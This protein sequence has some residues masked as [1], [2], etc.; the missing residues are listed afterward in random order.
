MKKQ[1]T[2]HRPSRVRESETP[3]TQ[4]PVQTFS[5]SQPK[6]VFS[7][8]S[9]KPTHLRTGAAEAPHTR[10]VSDNRRNSHPRGGKQP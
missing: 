3:T 5:E 4:F 2:I 6:G 1:S 9:A 10:P 7:H 8:S